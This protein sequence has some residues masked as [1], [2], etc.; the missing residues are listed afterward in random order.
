MTSVI[1]SEKEFLG[2]ENTFFIKGVLEAK[3]KDKT[4]EVSGTIFTSL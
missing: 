1:L 2:S 4:G 3:I